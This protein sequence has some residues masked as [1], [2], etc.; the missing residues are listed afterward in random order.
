[1][2]IAKPGRKTTWGDLRR[3]KKPKKIKEKEKSSR[4]WGDL[5]ETPKKKTSSIPK[6]HQKQQKEYKR[7]WPDVADETGKSVKTKGGEYKIYK[8]KSKSASSFRSAFADAR[9]SGKSIFTWR[10]R[11][12]TTKVK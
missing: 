6:K 8:K 7:S 9:K 1:M 5:K 4:T 2:P 10:G 11:K 12:Y 3:G